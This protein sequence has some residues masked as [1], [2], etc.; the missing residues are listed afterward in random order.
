M[1]LSLRLQTRRLTGKDFET[2]SPRLISTRIDVIDVE[3]SC[4]ID[5]VVQAVISSCSAMF[6]FQCNLASIT[7]IGYHFNCIVVY[8]L[9]ESYWNINTNIAVCVMCVCVRACVRAC[10]HACM[11]VCVVCSSYP[12]DKF[13]TPLFNP[14]QV[15]PCVRISLSNVASFFVTPDKSGCL[16][17]IQFMRSFFAVLVGEDLLVLCSSVGATKTERVSLCWRHVQCQKDGQAG[18]INAL[19]R[20]EFCKINAFYVILHYVGAGPRTAIGV[21]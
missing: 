21:L 8:C 18:E 6:F 1:S 9:K 3:Y 15:L 11:R 19:A 4:F 2:L 5:W 13:T 7:Q 17:Y 10:V 14:L 16:L 12:S 20:R